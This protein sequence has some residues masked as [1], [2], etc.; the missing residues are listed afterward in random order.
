MH[1]REKLFAQWF[2]AASLIVSLGVFGCGG[3]PTSTDRAGVRISG[4][5]SEL[6]GSCPRIRFKLASKRVGTDNSSA[7]VDRSCGDLRQG[8]P[9]EVEGGWN[10]DGSLMARKV[11][12]QHEPPEFEIRGTVSELT[13]TCPN[14]AFAV[15]TERLMTDASTR[16]RDQP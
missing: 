6:T 5:L 11:R 1:E 12:R 3:T 9:I 13:G 8:E 7:F 14:V 10:A 16:F 2:G 4:Q 15:G